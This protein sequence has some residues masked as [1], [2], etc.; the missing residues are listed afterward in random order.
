MEVDGENTGT[1]EGGKEKGKGKEAEAMIPGKRL[2]LIII[3][4]L[5]KRLTEWVK[6]KEWRNARIMVRRS[7]GN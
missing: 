5:G 6:G 7:E 2:H 1:G 3:E 4:E